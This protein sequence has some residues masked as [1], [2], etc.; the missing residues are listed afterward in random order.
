[1]TRKLLAALFLLG[2][3]GIITGPAVSAA[4]GGSVADF[5]D[6]QNQ[7]PDKQP[8]NPDQQQKSSTEL[9]QEPN[10]FVSF[11]K[12]MGSL[13]IVLLLIY[14]IYRF[15]LKRKKGFQ[16]SKQLDNL[17]GVALGANR[18]VQLVKIADEVLVVGVGEDITLL[19][20]IDDA[21]QLSQL[22]QS[23]APTEGHGHSV[24]KWVRERFRQQQSY[25][26]RNR[27]SFTHKLSEELKNISEDRSRRL[28]ETKRKDH[29]DG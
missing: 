1:M 6:N 7:G 14:G 28:R 15:L 10:T 21:D 2:F 12:L 23:E 13:M 25:K 19:K 16:T 8:D 18:S 26:S 3:I 17:G 27:P 9:K 4:D 24:Q 11:F 29:D 20:A 5:L 22:L